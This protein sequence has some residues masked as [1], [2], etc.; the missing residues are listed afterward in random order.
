MKIKKENRI[1]LYVD[2]LPTISLCGYLSTD[3]GFVHP[4]RILDVNVL[5]YVEEGSFHLYEESEEFTV[6]PGDL[7]FLKQGLHHFGDVKCP[8][9][10]KWFFIHFNMN[11][12]NNDNELNPYE[13][14]LFTESEPDKKHAYRMLPK[15]ARIDKKSRIFTRFMTLK[16]M[17]DSGDY[18][19]NLNINAYLY[20]ILTDIYEAGISEF[21]THPNQEKVFKMMS[22]LDE[23]SDRAFSSDEIEAYMG[24]TFKHLNL[25]F[26]Q[27]TGTTLWKYHCSLRTEK[28]GKLLTTTSLSVGEI[29]EKLGYESPYYFCNAFKKQTGMSPS[30]YR[31]DRII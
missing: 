29:S 24:L 11:E 31:K 2:V 4:D 18:S 14:Y 8:K 16:K 25:I 23:R 5:L 27:V 9:G 26:R 10:T 15:T 12:W 28:A 19:S 30:K 6:E 20:G 3:T 1:K 22:F 21:H 7:L 17:F 13:Q